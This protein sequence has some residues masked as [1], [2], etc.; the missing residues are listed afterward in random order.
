[1]NTVSAKTQNFWRIALVDVALLAAACL[2]PTLS[3]LTALPLYQLNPMLMVLLAGMLLVRDNRNAFVM[4]VL[5]PVVSML[6][7]GMPAPTKVLCMVPEFLTVVLVASL[8]MRKAQG[9]LGIF[10]SMVAA[11]IC[12]KV[13]YYGLKALVMGVAGLI[14]TPVLVQLLATVGLAMI[15]AAIVKK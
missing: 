10:G 1:M 6:A 11:I 8:L 13:V 4:A 9:F 7:V 14:S 2:I 5:L 3:H 15:F 12:G